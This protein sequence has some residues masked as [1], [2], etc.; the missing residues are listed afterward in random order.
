MTYLIGALLLL[1]AGLSTAWNIL[2]LA[3]LSFIALYAL[4][5]LRR[6][7]NVAYISDRIPHR[8]MASGLSV[9]SQI[10]MTAVAIAAPVIG[11][12]A[13]S[14]G[15]GGALSITSI[16]FLALLLLVRVDRTG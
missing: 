10:K 13:D 2:P 11:Y 15:I 5:N 1:L 3:V 7:M 9:E 14:I 16:F 8:T 12:M 4:Q 6:P